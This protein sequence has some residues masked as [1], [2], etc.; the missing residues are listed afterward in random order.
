MQKSWLAATL[1]SIGD[2]V[3]T[4]DAGSPPKITYLNP[5]A[6]ELTGFKL[7][8]ARN[9]T[10][11]DIFNV[12]NMTTRQ[13]IDYPLER[14]LH[15]GLIF[16]LPDP[17]ILISRNGNELAIEDCSAAIV[18]P[19][20]SIQGVVVVFRDATER[21]KLLEARMIAI[22]NLE[23]EKQNL[24]DLFMQTPIPLVMLEGPTFFVK[25]ANPLS[26]KRCPF[27]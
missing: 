24:H 9:K 8:E 5:V 23:R 6:E 2:A 20:G 27:R 7:E 16:C 15:Q 14:V 26:V 21:N 12:I 13:R 17:T 18:N 22:K 19:D 11:S 25:L 1:K 3:I 10:L 4:M